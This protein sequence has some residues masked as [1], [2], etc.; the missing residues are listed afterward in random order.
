MPDRPLK[1]EYRETRETATVA[2]GDIGMA[3]TRRYILGLVGEKSGGKSTVGAY[4]RS[5]GARVVRYSDILADILV[6]LHLDPQNRRNLG[7]LAEALRSAFPVGTISRAV[8]LEAQAVQ[9]KLTVVDGI[10]KPGELAYLRRLP[11]F[12]LLYVTAPPRLR[13]ERARKRN[14]RRDDRVSYRKFQSIERTY[15]AEVDIPKLGRRADF[16]IDNVGTEAE[17]SSK[18]DAV[19]KRMRRP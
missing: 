14:Q 5:K 12:R 18:V 3:S 10:R 9:S 7:T 15:P 11:N 19:L 2:L 13:Y 4:L 1:T 6:R 8:M 16:R 17:L